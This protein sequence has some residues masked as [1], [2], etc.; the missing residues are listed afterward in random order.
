MI[1]V[2]RGR[3]TYK[4]FT[5][6]YSLFFVKKKTVMNS[7]DPVKVKRE[8]ADSKLPIFSLITTC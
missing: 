1:T 6:L 5:E 8:L 7:D 2:V 3:R 4:R